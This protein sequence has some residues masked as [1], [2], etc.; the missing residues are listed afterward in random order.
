MRRPESLTG[1]FLA[2]PL[3]HPLHPPRPAGK[4]APSIEIAGASLH[5]LKN[6]AL[7]VPL[8]RLSVITG[9]SGSGK[10]TLARDILYRNLERTVGE[11]RKGKEA[12]LFGCRAIRGAQNIG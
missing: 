6:I 9:V 10:S 1:R 2:N 11:H 4:G 8:A 7:R 12:P 5:N 3:R